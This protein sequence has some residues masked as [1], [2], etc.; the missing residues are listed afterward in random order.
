MVG[1]SEL[2][3]RIRKRPVSQHVALTSAAL[4]SPQLHH[5]SVISSIPSATCFT[6]SDR[7]ISF[8]LPPQNFHKSLHSAIHDEQSKK[9]FA[10]ANRGRE[11]SN[12]RFCTSRIAEIRSVDWC[13]YRGMLPFQRY[14]GPMANFDGWLRRPLDDFESIHLSNGGDSSS[15]NY[16]LATIQSEA[17]S[18]DDDNE[19]DKERQ[20]LSSINNLTSM[21]REQRRQKR[22]FEAQRRASQ[23]LD[24]REHLK[25]IY[26]DEHIL[27]VSKASGALSVP[28]PRRNPSVANLCFT[29]F[30]NESDDVD[31]MAVHRLDLDTSGVVLYA[32]TDMALRTLNQA[33]RSRNVKKKY[34]A[35]LC[36]HM[37][38]LEGEIDIP[39]RRDKRSPPFMCVDTGDED[40]EDS[41]ERN[42]GKDDNKHRGFDKMMNKAPKPSLTLFHVLSFEY[43]D[44]LPVTRVELTPITGRTHQL[45]VHCASIG[46]PIIADDIYGVGGEG[47]PNGGIPDNVMDSTFPDRAS[48]ELQRDIDKVVQKRRK[49]VSGRGPDECVI[50]GGPGKLCLHARF[51]SL[52]HPLTNAG[53]VFEVDPLF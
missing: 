1:Q 50:T 22:K 24:P 44:G 18:V 52:L 34:Q 48:L 49:G 47:T 36:G 45:R 39:L 10:D 28:G 12:A 35:L 5:V 26:I 33:F 17:S 4:F 27:A 23:P 11:R 43:L 40:D 19:F 32:R 3:S 6:F 46:H 29:Y 41:N 13:G 16:S 38:A 30:G 20:D 31:K 14:R 25:P 42:A 53:L 37:A 2:P 15:W 51:L 9:C 21:E 8:Q 7:A